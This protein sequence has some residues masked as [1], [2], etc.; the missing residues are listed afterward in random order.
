MINNFEN[1]ALV[2][3]YEKTWSLLLVD[4]NEGNSHFYI[5]K[6]HMKGEYAAI[7]SSIIAEQFDLKNSVI[8]YVE[9]F[10]FHSPTEAKY[11]GTIVF[12]LLMW[13]I[14][15]PGNPMPFSEFTS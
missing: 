11:S 10:S 12:R 1:V 13:L 4:L 3:Y 8:N 5:F 6:D 2:I 9:N 7:L 15:P 14:D